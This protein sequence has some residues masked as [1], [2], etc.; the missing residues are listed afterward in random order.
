MSCLLFLQV[1]LGN[2]NWLSY[3]EAYLTA[4]CFGSGL[5]ALNQRPHCNIAIFCETRA[6]WLVAAQACF[7]YN[8]PRECLKDKLENVFFVALSNLEWTS[9]LWRSTPPWGSR[10][11]RTASTRRKW[12]TS[13]RVKTCC[14]ADSRY[15]FT[16]YFYYLSAAK[17][18]RVVFNQSFSSLLFCIFLF[19]SNFPFQAI[20]CDVPRL[21]YI[22]V[23]DPKPTS[24]PDIPRSIMVYNMDAV[25]EMGSKPENSELFFFSLIWLK[26]FLILSGTWRDTGGD[27]K[28]SQHPDV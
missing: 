4:K 3:E 2:Y 9:Q 20:L 12:P 15:Q 13:S 23:V 28:R 25:K 17:L 27:L 6:E 14:R 10:P 21:Q 5:A 16:V 22:I 19:G 11:S 18:S 7:M 24:W 1:I 26:W 8:F